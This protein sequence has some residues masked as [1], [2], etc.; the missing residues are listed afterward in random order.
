MTT[1]CSMETEGN[2]VIETF[3]TQDV[4]MYNINYMIL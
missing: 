4:Y 1:K 3:Q 2:K